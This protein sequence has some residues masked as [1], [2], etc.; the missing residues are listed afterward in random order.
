VAQISDAGNSRFELYLTQTRYLLS[1]QYSVLSPHH[2]SPQGLRPQLSELTAT[3]YS[4]CNIF[5]PP[6]RIGFVV[7]SARR[8]PRDTQ[9]IYR[10]KLM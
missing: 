9:I 6:N 3:E 5:E 4:M 8:S 1:T 10:D 7:S 2:L